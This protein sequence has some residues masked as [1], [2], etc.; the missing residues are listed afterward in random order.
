MGVFG[1]ALGRVISG[2]GGPARTIAAF[3]LLIDLRILSRGVRVLR[4]LSLDAV[5]TLVQ[6]QRRQHV[7]VEVP[8][9]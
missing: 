5:L 2:A 9:P 4:S 6:S 7:Q 1:G 3:Q 8:V